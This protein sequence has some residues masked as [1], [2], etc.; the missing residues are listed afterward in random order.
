MPA[1]FRFR[2]ATPFL[3]AALLGLAACTEQHDWRSINAADGSYSVM[4]PAKPSTVT[5]PVNV[6]GKE[7]SMTMTAAD[8][9]QVTFA[10]GVIHVP[11]PGMAAVTMTAMKDAL[12]KNI[13]SVPANEKIRSTAQVGSISIEVDTVGKA[14]GGAR[15]EPR[16]LHG[17]FIAK[18]TTVYQVVVAGPENA[19]IDTVV[20]TFL[21]S[22]KAN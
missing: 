4:M 5:R 13:G 19:V 15:G 2:R 6:N 17:R 7:Y 16:V 20:E 22:F 21:T 9:Q 11:E 1:I 3:F 8:V 14:S 12:L 10:V 18:G